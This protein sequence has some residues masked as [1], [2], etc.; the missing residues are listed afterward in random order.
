MKRLLLLIIILFIS[1]SAVSAS[2]NATADDNLL[3]SDNADVNVE[4]DSPDV[5]VGDSQNG[6][7]DSDAENESVNDV[8]VEAN[9]LVWYYKANPVYKFKLVDSNGTGV[10]ADNTFLIYQDTYIMGDPGHYMGS[11][12]IEVPEKYFTVK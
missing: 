6:T 7:A 3:V 11:T 12:E 1:I 9:D 2:D 10:K 8:T 4:G 5:N